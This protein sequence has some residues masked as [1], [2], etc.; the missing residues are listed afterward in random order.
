MLRYLIYCSSILLLAACNSEA[1]VVKTRAQLIEE[2]ID[3]RLAALQQRKMAGCQE[4]LLVEVLS[5]VDS[6]IAR[7]LRLDF[8]DTIAFPRRPARP[9]IPG[10]KIVLDTS[11]VTK[12]LGD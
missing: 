3:K 12:V 7:Q 6:T 4:D 9:R 8:V 1:P 2:G 5:D 11:P 10:G